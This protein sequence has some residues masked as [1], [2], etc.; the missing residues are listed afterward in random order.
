M[1][2]S[3]P[4]SSK[5]CYVKAFVLKNWKQLFLSKLILYLLGQEYDIY[6]SFLTYI[7][8]RYLRNIHEKKFWTHENTH[9]KKLWTHEGM[10]PRWHKAHE[11]YDGTKPRNLAH[12]FFFL[13]SDFLHKV[14][15]PTKTSE[16]ITYLTVQFRSKNLIH[17][18]NLDLLGIE[19]ICSRITTINLSHFTNFSAN[20]WSMPKKTLALH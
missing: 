1:S 12:S 13:I 10:V 4:S 15:K 19:N 2:A 6:F 7:F 8:L 17:F 5:I 18:T 20:I 11:T 3:I 14:S 9:E 16:K